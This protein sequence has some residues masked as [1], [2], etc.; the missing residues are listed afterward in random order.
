MRHYRQG[1]ILL[2]ERTSTSIE[3]LTPVAPEGDSMVLAHGEATGHRHRF[4]KDE[5]DLYELPGRTGGTERV[6]HARKLL[7]TLKHEEHAAIEL[8]AKDYTVLRQSEYVAK[9]PLRQVAD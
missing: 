5:V 1:D 6:L 4:H 9:A 3:G 2:I 8:P 7:A